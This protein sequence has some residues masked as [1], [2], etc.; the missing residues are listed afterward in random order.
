MPA[1]QYSLADTLS[2]VL[3][4]SRIRE[5]DGAHQQRVEQ[6]IGIA[7]QLVTTYPN[8][9]EYQSLQGR[10]QSDLAAAQVEAKQLEKAEKNYQAAIEQQRS[11]VS[12]YESVS[13]Y[14]L[15]YAQTL[16]ELAGL[17]RRHGQLEKARANLEEAA[18]QVEPFARSDQQTRRLY[19][20]FLQQV[21]QRLASTHRE[22]GDTELAG[23]FGRKANAIADRGRPPR[24]GRF[25]F[26]P[27][28]M[29]RRGWRADGGLK[30]RSVVGLP[31]RRG[32][33]LRGS[34]DPAGDRPLVARV[35]RPRRGP[36]KGLP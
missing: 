19:Q 14:R 32:S 29:N 36:T 34:P 30:Q 8:V 7:S 33:R 10:L 18:S 22:L 13:L 26:R 35:S 27:G 4:D 23:E 12:R 6:A 31:S 24:N 17:Q 25:R 16:Y 20:R 3:P 21:Y 28:G 2:L 1:F 15:S 5:V 11:L 9:P